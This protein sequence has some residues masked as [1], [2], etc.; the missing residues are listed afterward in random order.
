[1]LLHLC[2]KI[3]Q[4]EAVD[5][6]VYVN[7]QGRSLQRDLLMKYPFIRKL[8][9]LA[10]KFVVVPLARKNSGAMSVA[11]DGKPVTMYSDQGLALTTGWLKVGEHLYY[12]SLTESYLSKIDLTKS[13]VESLE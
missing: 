13:S 12:G 3:C 1:M 8:V 9:Y 11:L 7:L 10:E 6:I 5:S 2:S 4:A